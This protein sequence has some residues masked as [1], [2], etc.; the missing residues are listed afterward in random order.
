MIHETHKAEARI[1]STM[2]RWES[3]AILKSIWSYKHEGRNTVVDT[4]NRVFDAI[5]AE[6][7]KDP[8]V[9]ASSVSI[10]KEWIKASIIWKHGANPLETMLGIRTNGYQG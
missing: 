3:Q 9:V 4:L 6:D 2:K 7:W 8:F 1:P 10:P 5:C